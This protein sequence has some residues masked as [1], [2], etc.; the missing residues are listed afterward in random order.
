M[1][2]EG[3]TLKQWRRH[4]R[5]LDPSVC[6]RIPLRTNRDDRY[7]RESFQALPDRG[8]SAM[9]ERM[10][11]ASPRASLHLNTPFDEA[12]R[13]FRHR[14]LVFTGPIDDFFARRLGPLPYRSLRFEPESFSAP[15][16]APRLPVAGKPGFWQPAVQVNYPDP[17]VP[18][19]RIVEIKHATGQLT[20]ATTIIREFPADWSP[21]AE[22]FYPLPAPDAL[23]LYRRYATLARNE[24]HVTFLGRLATYR[25]CNMDQVTAL[26]LATAA[27]LVATLR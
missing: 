11:D 20:D 4:P 25:Y 9:F 22:P 10:L 26:A 14:H 18:F 24:P 7:L 13:R 16:L 17:A 27:K 2:F 8:Y 6:R 12:R 23:A 15:Q 5:D 19:T 3:Y 21:G 1:F